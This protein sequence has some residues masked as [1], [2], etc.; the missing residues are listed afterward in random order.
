M[1]NPPHYQILS[2]QAAHTGFIIEAIK[3]EEIDQLQLSSF[4]LWAGIN[5]D[6]SESAFS[7]DNPIKQILNLTKEKKIHTEIVIGI[8][9][10]SSRSGYKLPPCIYCV[11]AHR[12]MLQR[13]FQCR[14][15]WPNI[16]WFYHPENHTKLAIGSKKESCQWVITGGHNLA[17]SELEDFSIVLDKPG[18][19]FTNLF[20]N[21]KA[22]SDPDISEIRMEFEGKVQNAQTPIEPKCD[23]TPDGTHSKNG[24]FQTDNPGGKEPYP[25]PTQDRVIPPANDVTTLLLALARKEYLPKEE[26]TRVARSSAW[27]IDQTKGELRELGKEA[28][29]ENPEVLAAEKTYNDFKRSSQPH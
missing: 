20:E 21:L 7:S 16:F 17:D 18:N 13:I 10:F 14:K 28:F 8:P 26:F 24:I 3:A 5:N 29:K 19:Q 11:D 22:K 9:P 2:S 27:L 6:G 15:L 1:G 4:G 25:T 12:R 23:K